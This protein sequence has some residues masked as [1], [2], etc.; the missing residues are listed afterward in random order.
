MTRHKHEDDVKGASADQSANAGDA[1]STD[2][3]VLGIVASPGL[4]ERIAADVSRDL[5]DLLSGQID[6]QV[7]WNVQIVTDPLTGSNVEASELLDEV[8]KRLRIAE[9]DYAI[10]LADLP[11]RRDTQINIVDVSVDRN[12]GCVSIPALGVIRLRSRVRAA[13]LQIMSELCR[14]AHEDGIDSQQARSDTSTDASDQRT[15]TS[16]HRIWGMQMRRITPSDAGRGVDVSY[17]APSAM[18]YVRLLSGMVYANTPWTLFAGFK[19]TIAAA[20]ATG[21]YGMIFT[22]LWKLGDDYSV[23]RLMTLMIAAMA[24]LIAWTILAHNL[25]EK[26]EKRKSPY[27]TTLYNLATLFTITTAVIFAY[28]MIFILLFFAGVIF[29]PDSFLRSTL[30][31]PVSP[32]NYLRTAWITASVATVA[33]AIGAGLED[34]ETV[35]DATFG[36]RQQQRYAAYQKSSENQNA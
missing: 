34:T 14:G 11:L 8:Y 13:I 29:L 16:P 1:T 12:I 2:A 17:V 9:W 31:H 5:P 3:L 23:A 33:G 28:V 18:G 10:S 20:F 21:A 6:D 15:R 32:L 24:M 35:R 30:Q 22:T 19:S 4:G 36:W 25:W 27:L 7:S 26:Y